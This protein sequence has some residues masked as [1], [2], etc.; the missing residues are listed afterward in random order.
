M[1]PSRECLTWLRAARKLLAA[2]GVPHTGLLTVTIHNEHGQ[3]VQFLLPPDEDG[4]NKKRSR[5]ADMVGPT[6]V[7]RQLPPVEEAALAAAGNQPLSVKTLARKAGYKMGSHFSDAV[8][9]LC[10]LGKL[11]R[12]PEG[13]QRAEND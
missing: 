8:T 11:V 6:L 10:R 13:V 7:E 2:I 4:R 5:P 12:V 9:Q 1:P 3:G